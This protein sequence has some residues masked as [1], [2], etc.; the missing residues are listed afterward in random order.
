[1]A[2]YACDCWDAE[3]ES[4]YG[5]IECVGCADRSAYDLTVHAK[6]TGEKLVVR[7]PLAQPIIR[8]G[9]VLELNRKL[10]GPA[11]KKDAKAVQGYFE[12]LA[13]GDDWD[14]QKLADLQQ[15]LK[16]GN[17]SAAITGTDGKSYTISADMVKI[18]E[19]TVRK[20]GT[21]VIH[22]HRSPR[23][24]PSFAISSICCSRHPTLNSKPSS[25]SSQSASI[26]KSKHG[27]RSP[28]MDV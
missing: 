4:S 13:D 23:A 2:H 12:A 25:S 9:L 22:H 15:A 19:K 7:K 11:F 27:L 24:V 21:V 18:E 6:K 1:M 26:F 10:I 3:I 20:N 28:S 16:D 17:G 5:W 8:Q 14:Q